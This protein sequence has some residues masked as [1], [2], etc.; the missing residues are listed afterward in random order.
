MRIIVIITSKVISV[1]GNKLLR[2]EVKII[3]MMEMDQRMKMKSAEMNVSI[4][5]D[6]GMNILMKRIMIA[7]LRSE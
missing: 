2:I 5:M 6:R 7:L 3:L 4:T 1:K